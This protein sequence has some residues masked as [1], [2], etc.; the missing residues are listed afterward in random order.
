MVKD[1][2]RKIFGYY[3]VGDELL[4]PISTDRA[5]VVRVEKADCKGCLGC[6][7]FEKGIS[8]CVLFACLPAQRADRQKAV[9]KKTG[10]V[11][12]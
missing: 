12:L 5:A 1:L 8:A 11:K 10:E 4:I 7:L 6:Y 9:L 2:D 3:E